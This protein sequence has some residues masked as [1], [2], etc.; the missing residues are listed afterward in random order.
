MNPRPSRPTV[1]EVPG[2]PTPDSVRSPEQ[3][4]SDPITGNDLQV[5]RTLL[6][7]VPRG[8]GRV[9]Q[10][11]FDIT[12]PAFGYTV[13]AEPTQAATGNDVPPVLAARLSDPSRQAAL[14]RRRR[15][16]NLKV[17]SYSRW[18]ILPPPVDW[19]RTSMMGQHARSNALDRSSRAR[20]L[21]RA[22]VAQYIPIE[23]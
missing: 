12:D 15:R 11:G 6:K 14:A 9:L 18:R 10:H 16:S 13:N 1:S 23:E 4:T 5:E 20:A 7:P 19:R 2:R 21:G 17:W 8:I 22:E 3:P